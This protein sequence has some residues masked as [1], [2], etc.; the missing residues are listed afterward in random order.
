MALQILRHNQALLEETAQTLLQKEILEG[1]ELRSYLDRAESPAELP[2]WL[3]HGKAAV[4]L[5]FQSLPAMPQL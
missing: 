4:Q 3:R 1:E 2:H 5:P